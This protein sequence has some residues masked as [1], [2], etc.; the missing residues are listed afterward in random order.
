M[1]SK[2]HKDALY[3]RRNRIFGLL[4]IPF[5]IVVWCVGWGLSWIGEAKVKLKLKL[6]SQTEKLTIAGLLPQPKLK[7]RNRCYKAEASEKINKID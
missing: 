5:A 6:A 7:L 4:M 3:K 1:T 2:F